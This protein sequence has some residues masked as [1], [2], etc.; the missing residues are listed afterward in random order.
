MTKRS[1][2]A[3]PP[4][5]TTVVQRTSRATIHKSGGTVRYWPRALPNT[6]CDERLE[7]AVLLVTHSHCAREFRHSS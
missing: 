4:T 5:I 1:P 7:V 6:R 2:P 3:S